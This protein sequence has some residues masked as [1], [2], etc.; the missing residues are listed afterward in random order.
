MLELQSAK[1]IFGHA[2]NIWYKI[3]TYE[4][5]PPPTKQRKKKGVKTVNNQIRLKI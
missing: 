5:G 1:A 2:T 4:L 3:V